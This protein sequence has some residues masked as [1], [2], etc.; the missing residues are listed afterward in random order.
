MTAMTLG[1]ALELAGQYHRAGR[2]DVA[3]SLYRQILSFQPRHLD[4][5]QALGR[6]SYQLGRLDE[7]V[8]LIERAIALDPGSAA[9]H[10]NL[11]MTHATAGHF[12]QAVVAFLQA[13]ALNPEL[14][15]AC[16]NLGN[17]HKEMGSMDEAI[18]AYRQSVALRPTYVEAWLNL[19][20][21]LRETDRLDEAIASYRKTLEIRPDPA[22]A[23]Q[24]LHTL[25][26]H[27]DYDAAALLAEHRLWD[28]R[29]AQPLK[30]LIRPHANGR[31]PER[32]LHIGYVSPDFRKH[33][34]GQNML[35]ILREH[36]HSRFEIF[37]YSN[38]GVADSFTDQFRSYADGWRNIRTLSDEH[39]AELIR[40][41][42]IDIL[43]DLALHMAN[44]RLL[45]LA[46]KPAP[47][48]VTFAGYPGT[49]G[50][51][52]IDYRLTDPYLDPA[53]NGDGD[54]SEKSIRLADSF[55]CYDPITDE[56]PVNKLPALDSSVVT[57]G[58]L[59]N[60]WKT[61]HRVLRLWARVLAAVAGSR[62]ILLCRPG[63]HRQGIAELMRAEGIDPDRL[64]FVDRETRERYLC[65]YHRID[66]GLD[67]VPY[68][69]HT[70]SL[71][72]L[73][74]GVPVVT[75][76]GRTV[77]GRAGFSQ[78]SNLALTELVAHDEDQFVRIAATL[79]GDLPGLAGLRS[80][81]RQRLRAS[82]L[83]DAKRFTRSIEAAYHRMWRN[84]CELGFL[85]IF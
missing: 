46:R 38:V 17:A 35:P 18:A 47:V 22:A 79:A 81:L 62:L 84:W 74:M 50:L 25:L 9:L 15:E 54:Y 66:I 7:A 29:Y 36:D 53:G 70:T 11:G 76:V 5:L 2:L 31:D 23:S 42:K 64:E 39:A 51:E 52:A 60:F 30:H 13:L 1:Q 32:R 56:P 19:C 10:N 58:C 6:V 69:G 65:N 34:V 78:L 4:A 63:S 40:G 67:T 71:D 73:W 80:T 27:P 14:A 82:P 61:N 77:V 28:Q 37:C 57:F 85:Q 83:M 48:Q 33:V 59:N 12:E 43:V 21:A 55:W 41:D 45:V 26:A 8:E 3:A 16:N 20:T 44:H 24:L 49:T 72:S 68:N 75:L